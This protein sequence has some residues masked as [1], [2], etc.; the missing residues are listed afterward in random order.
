MNPQWVQGFIQ[1]AVNSPSLLRP[2]AARRL[3]PVGTAWWRFRGVPASS[4]DSQHLPDPAWVSHPSPGS[5][6]TLAVLHSPGHRPLAPGSAWTSAVTWGPRSPGCLGSYIHPSQQLHTLGETEYSLG[7]C[8][9][10]TLNTFSFFG[11][12]YWSS[13]RC[14]F[15]TSTVAFKKTV[16]SLC[17]TLR[18]KSSFSTLK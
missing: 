6:P 18:I 16:K 2:S 11:F 5:T 4:R 3:C 13:L 10:F 12:I 14:V 9:Q 1:P 7:S 15:K 8:P 17:S